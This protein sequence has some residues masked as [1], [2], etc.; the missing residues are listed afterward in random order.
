[1]IGLDWIGLDWIG[2]DW[3]ETPSQG[4]L[5]VSPANGGGEKGAAL[6]NAKTSGQRIQGRDAGKALTGGG[7][8]K[9]GGPVARRS[10]PHT[11][12]PGGDPPTKPRPA[13]PG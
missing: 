4:G 11:A 12:Q 3:K 7:K 8:H 10:P 6:P 2:L 5:G 13:T 1:M 9:R